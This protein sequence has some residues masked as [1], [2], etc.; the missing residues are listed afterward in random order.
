MWHERRPRL[1]WPWHW[2]PESGLHGGRE[3][4]RVVG[5]AACVWGAAGRAGSH[6]EDGRRGRSSAPTAQSSGRAQ[7][8]TGTPQGGRRRTGA[9]GAVARAARAGSGTRRVHWDPVSAPASFLLAPGRTG[10]SRG[11]PES[12]H[13]VRGTL[14]GASLSQVSP[15]GS[16]LLASGRKRHLSENCGRERA[17]GAP[18]GGGTPRFHLWDTDSNCRHRARGWWSLGPCGNEGQD[19]A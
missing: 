7:P 15:A 6:R 4:A 3:P 10:V 2:A 9:H 1:A 18:W 8:S 5:A 14:R 13:A 19:G 12:G 17:S 16:Y 11:P